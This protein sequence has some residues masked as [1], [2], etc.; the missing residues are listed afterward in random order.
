MKCIW[1]VEIPANRARIE[2]L[3]LGRSGPNGFGSTTAH[4]N[5]KPENLSKRIGK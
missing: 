4:A 3:V 1:A 2:S 5:G